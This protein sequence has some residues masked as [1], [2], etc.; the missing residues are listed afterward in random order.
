MHPDHSR[1]DYL[2]TDR[3]SIDLNQF[4]QGCK[5]L[6]G[7][8]STKLWLAGS[9]KLVHRDALRR[10]SS[11]PTFLTFTSQ[12][13]DMLT[14]S[15]R[16]EASDLD[17]TYDFIRLTHEMHCYMYLRVVPISMSFVTACDWRFDVR[18]LQHSVIAGP[19]LHGDGKRIPNSQRTNGPASFEPLRRRSVSVLMSQDD[20]PLISWE[21]S[22]G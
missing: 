8:D 14:E 11:T 16:L 22:N 19:H 21:M 6:L 13:H 1:L 18:G 2:Q 10:G 9:A 20:R 12:A 5:G 17:I 7:L 3:Q 4:R 15:R